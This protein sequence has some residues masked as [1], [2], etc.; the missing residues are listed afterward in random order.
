MGDWRMKLFALYDGDGNIV[1]AV[2]AGEDYGGPRPTAT[3]PGHRTDT[4]E[5]P[6]KHRGKALDEVCRA[7]RVSGET[8]QKLV[9]R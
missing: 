7:L 1:A 2:E 4:F 8:D 3:E 5:V 6:D 9:D